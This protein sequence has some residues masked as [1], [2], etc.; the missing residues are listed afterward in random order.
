MAKKATK[1]AAKSSEISKSSGGDEVLGKRAFKYVVGIG[2]V[3][4][5]VGVIAFFIWRSYSS[6]TSAAAGSGNLAAG[7]TVSYT[8]EPTKTMTISVRDFQNMFSTEIKD[9]YNGTY[10]LRRRD[11][12]MAWVKL[13]GE[14]LDDGVANAPYLI[15]NYTRNY[16]EML[17]ANSKGPRDGYV[18]QLG[19]VYFLS[20]GRFVRCTECNLSGTRI[21]DGKD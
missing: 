9:R 19:H 13:G 15:W 6:D 14:L 16:F 17:P 7:G 20:A 5:I 12:R 10:G 18:N 11:G 1:T 4:L 3:M 8:D 2:V 21:I